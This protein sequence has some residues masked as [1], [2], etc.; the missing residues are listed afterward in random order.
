MLAFLCLGLAG[1]QYGPSGCGWTYI[2][3][4]GSLRLRAKTATLGNLGNGI[5]GTAYNVAIPYML[6]TSS[7][8]IKGSAF[9]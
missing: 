4:S 3:E 1:A 8:G 9:W 7:F 5:L 6:T 2:G